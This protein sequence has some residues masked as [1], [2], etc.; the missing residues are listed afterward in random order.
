VDFI[1]FNNHFG[2]AVRMAQQKVSKNI[3]YGPSHSSALLTYVGVG[4]AHLTV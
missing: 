3:E 2:M 4:N 1:G